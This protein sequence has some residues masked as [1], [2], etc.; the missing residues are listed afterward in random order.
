[1]KYIKFPPIT[2]LIQGRKQSKEREQIKRN[3]ARQSLINMSLVN[4]S[5]LCLSMVWLGSCATP[6]TDYP[7]FEV[8]D[9]NATAMK[10]Q[11]SAIDRR[12][13]QQQRVQDIAWPIFAQNTDLCGDFT[14]QAYGF[15]VT[16]L[17]GLVEQV[18][19]LSKPQIRALGYDD[20]PFIMT[21]ADQS[22]ADKMGLRMGERI[23]HIN[24]QDIQGEMKLLTKALSEHHEALSKVHKSQ[25]IASQDF[26]EADTPETGDHETENPTSN[27]EKLSAEDK[28]QKAEGLPPLALTL[29]NET[30][31]REIN[32]HAQEICSP[33]ISA[34]PRQIINATAAPWGLTIYAGL[35]DR[36][37]DD[38]VVAFIIGHEL[39]HYIGRHAQ[40][41]TLN[42]V[43]SGYFVWGTGFGILAG[44][45]DTLTAGPLER[46]AGV[47][48]PLGAQ[49]SSTLLKKSLGTPDFEREADYLGLYLS[50]RAGFDISNAE[51]FFEEISTL[52]PRATY[53][54]STHP[55]T[56]ERIEGVKFTR[57]EIQNK[58]EQNLPLIPNGW[59]VDDVEPET[60][61]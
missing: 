15:S 6:Q 23:T 43:K 45:F 22:P 33:P 61:P 7:R 57:K 13:S 8:A 52:A 32:L 59:L 12:M 16:N 50:Y 37:E 26:A 18:D 21:I 48:N 44:V 46:F 55:P 58:A 56:A 49:A 14:R 42:G 19:G 28:T 38:N 35:L 9:F 10:A 17:D 54:E 11:I 3:P 47:E 20:R 40:K 34:H 25:K 51:F 41:Q 53:L 4:V 30:G 36:L 1:M 60:S 5:A 31:T 24:G 39:G 27:A 2:K 29:E